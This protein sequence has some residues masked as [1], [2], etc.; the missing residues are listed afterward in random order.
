[1][2]KNNIRTVPVVDEDER[3]IGIVT[4]ADVTNK[5]MDAIDNNTIASTKTSLRSIVETLNG[6]LICGFKETFSTSGRVVVAVAE[7]DELK[8]FIEVGYIITAA[9][10]IFNQE[11][12]EYYLAN[13]KIGIGQIIS[14][15]MKNWIKKEKILQLI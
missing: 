7:S 6:K 13:H 1:M 10:E 8:R 5:Y 3:L 9:E 14:Q 12:K 2:K 15:I 4:L 11:F